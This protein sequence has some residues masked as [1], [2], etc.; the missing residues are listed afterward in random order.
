M[1]AEELKKVYRRLALIHH[2]DKNPDN[3]R[4]A[5]AKFQ[6]IQAAV[7]TLSNTRKK[8]EYDREYRQRENKRKREESCREREQKRWKQEDQNEERHDKRKRQEDED[9]DSSEEEFT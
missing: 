3:V 6:L 9:E 4:E 7:E 5:T 2:P 8:A 1:S